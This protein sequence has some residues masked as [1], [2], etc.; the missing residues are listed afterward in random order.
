MELILV[1]DTLKIT[2]ELN[3]NGTANIEV[4]VSDGNLEDTTEFALILTPVQD[5]PLPFDL[6]APGSDSTI[7]I[8]AENEYN[9]SMELTWDPAIDPDGETVSYELVLTGDLEQLPAR[10]IYSGATSV[11]WMYYEISNAIS[12][13]GTSMFTG[14]WTI[15][16]SDPLDSTTSAANGPFNLTIDASAIL[17][18]DGQ[19]LIPE[20][21]ALHGN[22]PNP[23]NPATT[24]RYDLPEAANVTLTVYDLLGREVVRLVDGR[25]EAG[26]Q[27]VI[28]DG[29]TA[30]GR[31]VPS[32]IYIARM[33]TPRY[34]K[35][36]KM[37]LLK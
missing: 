2:P 1:E 32:G 33:I 15:E 37:V 17:S 19:G 4:I 12:G 6:L 3:W 16:A 7:T 34:H 11:S 13:A 21:Y 24:I 30:S 36:M 27:Q 29:R 14:T 23:F 26:F 8:T 18:A 25:M 28:W 9:Q 5:S 35:S 22:Y 20:E 10:T 31:E